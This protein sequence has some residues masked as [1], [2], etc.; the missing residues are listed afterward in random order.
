M[1]KT[2][3]QWVANTLALSSQWL[4]GAQ[5]TSVA[6]MPT[7]PCIYYANH[8]SHGDFVL[9]WASLSKA[10]RKRTRPI[11]G[12]DYWAGGR[13][14][15]YIGH[16]VFRA[17]MVDRAS[18]R[19]AAGLIDQMVKALDEGDSLIVF[20]EGTRN[21]SEQALMPFKAGIYHIASRR[22]A[23]PFVPVWINNINR[24]LP[25][26]HWLPVPL[27]CQLSY[28]VPWGLQEA[29]DKDEFLTQAE[30]RLLALRSDNHE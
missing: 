13:L 14:K 22:P 24:V 9:L 12:K 7:E 26:G 19:H 3:D 15:S 25:K 16:R 2:L 20:P 21:L 10:L 1:N 17:L 11:A 4:T 28:G 6:D 5:V 8:S 30:Q 23:T 27:L 29:P 18:A